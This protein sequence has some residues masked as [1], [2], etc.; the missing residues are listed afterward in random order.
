[1]EQVEEVALCGSYGCSGSMPL[2]RL[3]RVGTLYKFNPVS[4]SYPSHGATMGIFS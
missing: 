1:M 4:L 3:R 2:K